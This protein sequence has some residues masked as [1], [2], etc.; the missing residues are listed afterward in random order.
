MTPVVVYGKTCENPFTGFP[1]EGNMT[2]KKFALITSFLISFGLLAIP[3]ASSAP[4]KYT[5][6]LSGD[7][8]ESKTEGTIEEDVTEYCRIE[9]TISPAKPFRVVNLQYLDEDEVWQFADDING[10]KISIKSNASKLVRI[11]IPYLD[12]DGVFF[13]FEQRKFR[14]YIAKS[15]SSTAVASKPFIINYQAA[16]GMGDEAEEVE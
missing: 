3:T 13:D 16:G 15:G 14:V 7:C 11:D 2:N 12:S 1:E 8:A 10:D 9:T 5:F 4:Q 6:K